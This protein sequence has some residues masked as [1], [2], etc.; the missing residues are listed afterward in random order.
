MDKIVLGAR[1]RE[2]R[3]KCKFTQEVLAEKA[4]I[5]VMYLGEIER[6]IKM[7]SLNVFIRLVEALNISADYILRDELSSGRD[8]VFDELTAKLSPL[9]PKQRKAASD[10]L[11]A[12]IRNL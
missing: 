3:N 8:F 12:F 9:T 11:D 5:G 2:A 4:D 6:G 7:P 1:I 10:I